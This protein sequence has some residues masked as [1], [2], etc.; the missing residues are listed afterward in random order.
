MNSNTDIINNVIGE[1][2]NFVSKDNWLTDFKSLDYKT[3]ELLIS[4]IY[5]EYS[6]GIIS[7]FKE[8]DPDIHLT[9]I[10]TL[11]IRKSRKQFLDL[12]KS[13][14]PIPDAVQK[15]K[16]DYRILKNKPAKS[17]NNGFKET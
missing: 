10:G 4:S 3:K 2:H 11:K 7:A 1:L 15:C 16:D 13:G 14:V 12:V 17:I 6:I 8:Q 9:A 5:K